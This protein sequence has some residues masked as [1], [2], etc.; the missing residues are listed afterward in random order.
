MIVL[1]SNYILEFLEI[2]CDKD[3]L[4][5]EFISRYSNIIKQDKKKPLFSLTNRYSSFPKYKTD[6]YKKH[7]L[8]KSK[9]AWIPD[10]KDNN[11]CKMIKGILNK[12]TDTNYKK[13][14]E[15][16]LLYVSKIKSYELFSILSNEIFEKCIYDLKYHEIFFDI[17]Q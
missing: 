12:V 7:A 8:T 16:L 14:C 10:K 11:I 2:I 5:D 1:N 4:L 3:P 6:R 17:I 15:K 9:N 13:C